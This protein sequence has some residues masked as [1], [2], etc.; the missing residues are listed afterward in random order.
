MQVKNLVRVYL[1]F[2]Y[3][4]IYIK[5]SLDYCI[6]LQDEC[7]YS[8]LFLLLTLKFFSPEKMSW[9][10]LFILKIQRKEHLWWHFKSIR[11]PVTFGCL[12]NCTHLPVPATRNSCDSHWLFV[13]ENERMRCLLFSGF[14]SL[15]FFLIVTLTFYASEQCCLFTLTVSIYKVLVQ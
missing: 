15:F 2:I 4:Y 1:Y 5:Y 3:G 14:Q 6:V 8:S 12:A 7:Y 13:M 11:S 10:T 9:S